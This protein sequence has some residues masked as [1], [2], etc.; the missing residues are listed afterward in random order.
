[1]IVHARH[2]ETSIR[3][4]CR[5]DYRRVARGRSRCVRS[6][7]MPV[8]PSPARRAA[9]IALGLTFAGAVLKLTACIIDPTPPH[10]HVQQ[11]DTTS[12]PPDAAVPDDAASDAG[13]EP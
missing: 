10:P 4:G 11:S 3:N 7:A 8:S 6:R 1:M 9:S 12:D 5:V 2:G 13:G